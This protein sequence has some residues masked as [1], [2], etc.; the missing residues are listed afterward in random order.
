MVYASSQSKNPRSCTVPHSRSEIVAPAT[1][2]Y[3]NTVASAPS[4]ITTNVSLVSSLF[5]ETSSLNP[6]HFSLK[7]FILQANA[8]QTS[9]TGP[10]SQAAHFS[11]P[12]HAH[13]LPPAQHST[14]NVASPIPSYD[15]TL[16]LATKLRSLA[17][18][19]LKRIAPAELTAEGRPTI[20]ILLWITS[21]EDYLQK[22]KSRVLSII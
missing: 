3:P 19:Y 22:V 5:P 6:L 15:A 20:K 14:G 8:N 10:V 4:L 1:F 18:K 7:L 21:L 9:T 17:D 16:N 2:P 12:Q 11:A 13:D